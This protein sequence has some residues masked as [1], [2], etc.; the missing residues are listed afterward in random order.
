MLGAYGGAQLA[1][2][3]S[4]T[5]QLAVLG[6][7]MIAAAISMLRSSGGA[8]P[9]RA[10][11]R[12]QPMALIA[13]VGLGVGVLTG[14]VGIGGG[15]VIVP[16]LVL[17]VGIPIRQAIGTSLAVIAMNCLSGFLGYLG[18]APF[19]WPA[20][21][22]FTIVTVAGTLA[23]TRVGARVRVAH[24]KQGFAIFLLLLAA[25]ILFQNRGALL[26]PS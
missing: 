18:Q 1:R 23:G 26:G 3:I 9:P 20:I 4:G 17:V 12:P 5:V 19:D 16:A 25:Y 2:L 13:L 8:E 11:D 24:L 21:G 15:F 7:V 10:S 6:V 14:L 22:L